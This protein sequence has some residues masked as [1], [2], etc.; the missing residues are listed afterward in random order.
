MTFSSV[1]EARRRARRVLPKVV[2]DYVDGAADDERTMAANESAFHEVTFRPRVGTGVQVPALATEVLGTTLDLPVVLAPC[3]LVRLLHP[4]GA[5]GVARAAAAAGTVSVL[6]TVAGSPVEDV[7]PAAS[8][9]VWF[10]LYA[11]GRAEAEALVARAAAAGCPVLVV[12]LD[13]PVLGNRERDVRNRVVPPLRLVGSAV[14]LGP[15]VL[16]RPRWS[17]RLARTGVRMLRQPRHQGTSAPPAPTA[18]AVAMAAS[19]FTWEDVAWLRSV[20]RG[21]LVVKGLLT[22]D[23]ARRAADAGAEGVVV[24]N[25]GGRQLDRAP[26]ALRALPEVAAAVGDRLEVL[27][28]GGVRRGSDVATALAL[29]ARAVLVGRP[30]LYGL[31]VG[32]EPGVARVLEILRGELARTLALLGCPDVRQLDASWVI[33][34]PV[35]PSAGPRP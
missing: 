25:H 22:G 31:A 17:L 6:S 13:T 19:P 33:P 26:A 4:D 7:A 10:Q 32:G 1:A 9:T 27:V 23:D 24:S 12:T 30:Y 18:S 14:H 16:R 29:G 20:W 21:P 11:R 34:T 8:G 2:F 3:G 28:D 5:V 15:Q 35:P